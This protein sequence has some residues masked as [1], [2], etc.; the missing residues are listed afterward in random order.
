MTN[1]GIGMCL[2]AFVNI[3]TYDTII[4]EKITNIMNETVP[5]YPNSRLYNT[6]VVNSQLAL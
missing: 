2:L 5:I 4:L 6:I 3:S 1:C